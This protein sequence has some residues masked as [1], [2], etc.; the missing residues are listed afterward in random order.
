M[1]EGR[2]QEVEGVVL[3]RLKMM[4]II[5]CRAKRRGTR[6]VTLAHTQEKN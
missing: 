3:E 1:M 6:S 2:V 4:T 5:K